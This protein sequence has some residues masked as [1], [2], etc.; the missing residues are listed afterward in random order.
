[1]RE[2]IPDLVD[3]FNEYDAKKQ[4]EFER[5]PKCE[6]CGETIADEFF[7][8]LDGDIICESCLNDNFRKAVEDYVE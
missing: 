2:Y 3:C 1:M 8:D 4:R 7:F 6:Y 5:L